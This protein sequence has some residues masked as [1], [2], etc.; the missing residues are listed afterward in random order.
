MCSLS[1]FFTA[2]VTFIAK[3][4]VQ[5]KPQSLPLNLEFHFSIHPFNNYK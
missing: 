4:D 3:K 2:C 1:L 5:E